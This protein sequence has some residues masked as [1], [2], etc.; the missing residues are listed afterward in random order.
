MK[1]LFIRNDDV[2]DEFDCSDGRKEILK[3]LVNICIKEKAP[4]LLAVIPVRLGVKTKN[5]LNKMVRKYPKIISIC[6]HGYSHTDHGCRE[7]GSCRSHEQQYA[8]IKNGLDIMK[9]SFGKHPRIFVP[10]HNIYNEDTLM[11]LKKLGFSTISAKYKTD[12]IRRFVYSFGRALGKKTLF[13]MPVSNHMQKKDGIKEISI[14]VDII[15]KY[16]PV[17]FKKE[18]NILEEVRY[19][20]ALFS[21]VGIMTHNWTLNKEGLR[22]FR[23][24]LIRSKSCGYCFRSVRA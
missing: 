1:Y 10:P 12:G 5:W 20:S 13:G 19:Y 22:M 2:G 21:T 11:V 17:R 24:I 4:I 16:R 9:K 23:N 6:Q 8:D 18:E 3:E 7:F 14:S 15:D